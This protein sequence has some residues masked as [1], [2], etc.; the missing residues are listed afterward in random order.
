VEN[1]DI[2]PDRLLF[3]HSALSGQPGFLILSEDNP[4]SFRLGRGR[5]SAHVSVVHDS[6]EGRD[7]DDEQRIQVPRGVLETQERRRDEGYIPLF[8]GF[9]PDGRTFTA[10]EPD[11]VLSQQPGKN[12][13]VYARRSH[14]RLA[15]LTG[16][17]GRLVTRTRYL[18]RDTLVLTLRSRDLPKYCEEWAAAHRAR[19]ADDLR[20]L[21]EI[22]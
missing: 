4:I 5:Y 19:S 18:G 2:S 22:A 15:A 8:L 17:A 10:W 7:N 21:L 3:I 16:A 20:S 9:F 12:G 13:S 1:S 11:Y 14:G 6:G